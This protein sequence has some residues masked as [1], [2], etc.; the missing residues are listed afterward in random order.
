MNIRKLALDMLL[1][2]ELYGKYVN[3]RV[4]EL[5]NVLCGTVI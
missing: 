5:T 4:D 2:Y 1:D 3:V